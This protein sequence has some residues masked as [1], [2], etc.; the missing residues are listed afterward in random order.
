MQKGD[1]LQGLIRWKTMHDVGT[2]EMKFNFSRKMLCEKSEKFF[3]V[4][5]DVE[6][7]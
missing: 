7:Q 4:F 2:P 1:A 3:Q 6:L 5:S